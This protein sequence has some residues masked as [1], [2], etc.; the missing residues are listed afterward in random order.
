MD[1]KR[2]LQ[3]TRCTTRKK[4][5][6]SNTH[7]CL[8]L[9]CTDPG[10]PCCTLTSSQKYS[11]NHTVTFLRSFWYR[12]AAWPSSSENWPCRSSVHAGCK[13]PYLEP[14]LPSFLMALQKPA[15]DIVETT[16]MF[17][18]VCFSPGR[19]ST[20]MW[21]CV[22]VAS[23]LHQHRSSLQSA[24]QSVK[25]SLTKNTDENRGSEAQVEAAESAAMLSESLITLRV[26]TTRLAGNVCHIHHFSLAC[27]HTKSS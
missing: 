9:R 24:G 11:W 22:C 7:P 21:S 16:S 26:L 5:Q 3:H 14:L 6:K 10:C 13:D 18:T 17:Y 12:G 25:V 23:V 8:S 20:H 19:H 27:W 15:V 2:L 1:T 4:E